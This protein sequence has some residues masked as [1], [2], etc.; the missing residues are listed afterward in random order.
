MTAAD[1]VVT[2]RG[3]AQQVKVFNAA[4]KLLR[5]IGTEGGR[6]PR[7]LHRPDGMYRPLGLTVDA[8]GTL[9]V[10]EED[11]RPQRVSLWNAATG[12][13]VREYIGAC[14]YGAL[15][16]RVPEMDK[17][18]AFGEG[19][20]YQLDWAAK[21]YRYLATVGRAQSEEDVFGRAVVRRLFKRD[22]RLITASNQHV[23][24]VCEL[25]DNVLH[26][27]AAVGDL[28]E[29]TRRLGM[30]CGAL[31][32][33]IEQLKAAGAKVDGRGFPSAAFIWVDQNGD[34]IAQDSEFI[35]KEGL[36]WGGYWGAG[37]GDDLTIYMQSGNQAYRLPVTKW[38]NVGAPVYT[39]ESATTLSFTGNAE[40]MAPS[41]DGVLIVNPGSASQRRHQPGCTV[42]VLE[43][44]ASGDISAR[45][46]ELDEFGE[47]A[48]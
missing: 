20:Q 47:R 40:H 42:G 34:G 18:I 33:K 10:M 8:K 41:P 27:L 30:H 19:V 15:A 31:A 1:L 16:G 44:D 21:T 39:F 23:Q 37:I 11:D 35:W 43:I 2:D 13:F 4:G 28:D 48:R 3:K 7:G 9:W 45:I 6:S 32:R 22:G 38:N 17:N 5:A 46:I 24:V 36:R 26:P 25:K 29:L 12:A 14:H